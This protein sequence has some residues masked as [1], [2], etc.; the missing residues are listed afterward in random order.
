MPFALLHAFSHESSGFD[1]PIF[2]IILNFHEEKFKLYLSIRFT[3]NL[4]NKQM[5]QKY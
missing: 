1:E 5:N 4:K 3:I 2:L